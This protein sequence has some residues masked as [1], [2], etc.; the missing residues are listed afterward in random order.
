MFA[1]IFSRRHKQTTFS[2]ASFLGALRVNIFII[3]FPRKN[4]KQISKLNF[5][6]KRKKKAISGVSY[7]N[8]YILTLLLLNTS[9]PVVANSVDPDQ[10]ASEEAN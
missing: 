6:A 2:D 5:G 9:C 4:K 10:L 7:L 3:M 8:Y 1:R